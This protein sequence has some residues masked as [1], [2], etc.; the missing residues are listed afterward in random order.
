M[1]LPSGLATMWSALTAATQPLDLAIT[2]VFL[3]QL[4]D[5]TAPL[6]AGHDPRELVTI[7]LTWQ[8]LATEPRLGDALDLLASRIN[9]I[10][11]H[12]HLPSGFSAL[13]PQSVKSAYEGASKWQVWEYITGGDM[14]GSLLEQT[15]SARTASANG[16]FYTPYNVSYA[17]AMM[18]CPHPGEKIIDPACGSGRMLL[19]KL[20]ACR[21]Q[22]GGEPDL[23]GVDIDADA[24][25][26]CRLNLLLAGKGLGRSSVPLRPVG[27][28]PAR[29]A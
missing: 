19:A 14:L 2:L 18:L 24:V 17:M 13:D 28:S 16:A 15:R 6:V 3:R 27:P 20:H 25:R 9:E 5:P 10:T 12:E 21:V 8:E 7:S 22:F 29:A 4:F 1:K 11:G 23:Y 26:V